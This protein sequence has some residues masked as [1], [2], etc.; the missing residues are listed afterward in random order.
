MHERL[1]WTGRFDTWRDI[2]HPLLNIVQDSV[3]LKSTAPI[4]DARHEKK[5]HTPIRFRID[6]LG[7]KSEFGLDDV[8]GWMGSLIESLSMEIVSKEVDRDEAVFEF[9]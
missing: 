1:L 6:K 8:I 2:D 3:K 4:S 9:K 5:L 7:G